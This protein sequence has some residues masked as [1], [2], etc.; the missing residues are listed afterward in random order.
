MKK[1]KLR[2]DRKSESIARPS[3]SKFQKSA[4]SKLS[5]LEMVVL[6]SLPVDAA[7]LYHFNSSSQPATVAVA[8]KEVFI[9]KST[10][11]RILPPIEMEPIQLSQA[12]P[13]VVASP[14]PVI[15]KEVQ[16]QPQIS[17][18]LAEE[19]RL[20]KEQLNDWGAQL[21]TWNLEGNKV[22]KESMA[23]MA[24]EIP[25]EAPR[26]QRYIGRMIY[27]F[28]NEP[29]FNSNAARA[30]GNTSASMAMSAQGPGVR[31]FL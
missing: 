19:I 27:A 10:M 3:E 18:E 6:A 23:K 4:L 15:Q 9:P 17:A 13:K 21:V 30:N 5:A 11:E 7:L 14:I 22:V 28:Q 31:R 25:K 16:N 26:K 29:N 8:P 12:L 2:F 24:R 20:E 1:N